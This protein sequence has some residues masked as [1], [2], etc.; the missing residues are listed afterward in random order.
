MPELVLTRA[1]M[2]L[3]FLGGGSDL[4]LYVDGRGE[5]GCVLSATIDCW[6]YVVAKRRH[7]HRIVAH[8][9]QIEQRQNIDEL[10]NDH[11]REAL[12]YAG[13]DPDFDGGIE[14]VSIGDVS[15]ERSG[16]GGSSAFLVA[17]LLALW[18]LQQRV[19][20]ADPE[21]SLAEAAFRLE[22]QYI[23]KQAG[24]QDHY[25]AAFGGFNRYDFM[26]DEAVVVT[27]MSRGSLDLV[28]S[29]QLLLLSSGI[30]HVGGNVFEDVH[31]RENRERNL[32]LYG[33]LADLARK[34]A[35][36]I[37]QG[38][39]E[40]AF[41]LI[42]DS[43]LAKRGTSELVSPPFI[44]EIYRQVIAAGAHGGKVCG[45][46]GGGAMLFWC[47]DGKAGVLERLHGKYKEIGFHFTD[48]GVETLLEV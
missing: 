34:G 42:G 11:I 15:L 21:R 46:G 45:T 31:R 2:R 24:R 13:W 12:K 38:D 20:T 37:E 44:D 41:A 7:D 5:W 27:Q 22:T 33:F 48:R 26:E 23:G 16:L 6:V 28:A 39:M 9:Q 40:R 47:P 36:L 25:A 19:A 17:L 10:K 29:D 4:P 18:R 35:R 43:W 14:I 3:S 1:P 30:D 32:K 8:Y